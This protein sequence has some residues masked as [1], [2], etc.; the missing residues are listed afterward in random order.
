MRV[1]N[2]TSRLK[3]EDNGSCWLGLLSVFFFLAAFTTSAAPL[4]SITDFVTCEN[5]NTNYP[6]DW[7]VPQA[8]F[9][10]DADRF[11]AWVE[12]RDVSGKHPVEMKLY[13]PDGTYFGK[14]TQH[15]NETNGPASWWRM[16]AW[17]S[18][19]GDAP[20][21]SPGYWKLDLV[22]DGALQRSILLNI[23][24]GN[25]VASNEQ[26]PASSLLQSRTTAVPAAAV[27]SLKN[28]VYITATNLIAGANYQLQISPDLITWTNQGAVFTA[29]NS[30]WQSSEYWDENNGN[31][32]FFRLQMI[33]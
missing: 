9:R 1:R 15:I 20:A 11:F 21:Q 4:Y 28:A 33:Q 19:K 7:H 10:T 2:S 5:V 23:I 29:T 13:R 24:S 18:I 8:V 17:W 32:L 25:P 14:E 22:I 3:Q 16:Y 30:Y 31:Q 12:L 26:T 6:N 27:L